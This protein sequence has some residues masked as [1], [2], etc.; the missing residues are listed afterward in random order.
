M[1]GLIFNLSSEVVTDFDSFI[2]NF[3]IDLGRNVLNSPLSGAV[4]CICIKASTSKYY[5]QFAISPASNTI[6]T[7]YIHPSDG[8][9][10]EWGLII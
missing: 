10:G 6:Y 4:V 8:D 9:K 2:Y 3:K 7:R 5:R 1:G